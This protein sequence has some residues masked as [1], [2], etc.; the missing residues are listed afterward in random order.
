MKRPIYETKSDRSAAS[1][2]LDFMSSV[3]DFSEV[4]EMEPLHTADFL[5]RKGAFEAYVEVKCRRNA[6]RTYPTYMLSKSKYDALLELGKPAMLVVEWSD[7]VG[8]APLPARH[9]TGQGGRRDQI[10]KASI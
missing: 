9:T 3:L 2:V 1:R 6:S 5:V 10:K 7:G 4:R 8:I